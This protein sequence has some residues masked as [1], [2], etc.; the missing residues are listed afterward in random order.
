[1]LIDLRR[2]VGLCQAR[3]VAS[4]PS[5]TSPLGQFR[6]TVS[7]YEASDVVALRGLPASS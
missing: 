7:Q 5:K 1:M 2:C 3:T 6:T 4:A